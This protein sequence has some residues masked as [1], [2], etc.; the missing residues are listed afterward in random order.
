MSLDVR[1]FTVSVTP[2]LD[3]RLDDLKRSRYWHTTQ[4]EMIR[5]L[6]SLGLLH[7]EGYTEE[8]KETATPEVPEA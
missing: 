3:R 6:I 7:F 8:T 4:S 5:D 2:E 1:R